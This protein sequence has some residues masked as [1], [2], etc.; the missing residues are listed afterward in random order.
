MKKKEGK[1]CRTLFDKL[2]HS[3]NISRISK[4]KHGFL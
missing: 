1:F 2:A 3:A 4:K